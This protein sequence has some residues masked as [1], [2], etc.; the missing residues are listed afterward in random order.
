MNDDQI[1][2]LFFTRSEDAIQQT[3]YKY[4]ARLAGLAVNIVKSNEDA[5]ECVNDTYLK[6]WDTIPPTRPDHFFAYLA[7]ICRCF[8]FG[9]LDWKN[10]AKR[11]AEVVALTQEMEECIPGSCQ[12]D[13]MEGRELSAI[14]SAFLRTQTPE[15]RMIFVRRYWYADSIEEIAGRYEIT[16][17]AVLM[18]LSRTRTKLA[19][20]LKK[21][22]IRV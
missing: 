1:I 6:A 18:R 19:A 11:K 9:R 8:A 15:N 14:I 13:Q 10:A 22:G 5:E 17:S 7:K 16:Q 3:A 4:G 12:D 2:N 21:E 20:Y